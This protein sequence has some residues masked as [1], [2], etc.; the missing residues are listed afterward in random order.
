MKRESTHLRLQDEPDDQTRNQNANTGE[1]ASI[2]PSAIT[3]VSGME[4]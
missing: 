4:R 3:G 1:S 2:P